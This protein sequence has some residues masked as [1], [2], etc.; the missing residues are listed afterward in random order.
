MTIGTAIKITVRAKRNPT[1]MQSRKYI[2]KRELPIKEI[3]KILGIDKI[4]PVHVTSSIT[5]QIAQDDFKEMYEYELRKYF[6]NL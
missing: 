3:E 6:S 2:L 5:K 1:S 4:E